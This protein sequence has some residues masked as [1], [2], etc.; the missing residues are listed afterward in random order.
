MA[1]PMDVDGADFQTDVLQFDETPVLVDFWSPTCGHCLALNP[2][3]DQLAA[4]RDGEVRFAKVSYP[5]N[6]ELFEEYSVRATPTL[7]LLKGGEEVARTVGAKR[8][9]E[10][11]EWLQENLAD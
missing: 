10:L 9:E 1:K 4:E 5:D 8:A 6:K 11:N 3:F 2:H 7:V